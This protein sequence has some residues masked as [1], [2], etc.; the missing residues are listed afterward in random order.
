MIQRISAAD[1]KPHS[2]PPPQA[3]VAVMKKAQTVQLEQAQTL[4]H[5]NLRV[6]RGFGGRA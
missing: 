3:Q 4:I 5:R 1:M 6:G 2:I